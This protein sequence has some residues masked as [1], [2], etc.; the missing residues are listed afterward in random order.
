MFI[1]GISVGF[2]YSWELTLVMMSVAPLMAIGGAVMAKMIGEAAGSG[3]GFYARA[4]AIADETLRM[5]RTVIAFGSCLRPG[6]TGSGL[7][8]TSATT[9]RSWLLLR[10]FI[11]LLIFY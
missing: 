4:G 6:Y 10:C 3:Q 11:A 5:I 9:S 2:A 1:G 8:S 7:W